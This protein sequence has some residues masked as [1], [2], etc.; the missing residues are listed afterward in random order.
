M[1]S[2][3]I[4]NHC[5]VQLSV[6]TNAVEVQARFDEAF[7]EVIADLTRRDTY[8]RAVIEAAAEGASRTQAAEQT[9]TYLT[10]R[11]IYRV[12]AARAALRASHRLFRE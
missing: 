10:L 11:D 3:E 1:Y 4:S 12:A 6:L 2:I 5:I 9:A 8:R 7:N